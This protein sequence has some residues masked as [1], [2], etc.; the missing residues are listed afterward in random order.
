MHGPSKY[1]RGSGGGGG[2]GPG[3]SAT[4]FFSHQLNLRSFLKKTI[5]FQ[6]SREGPTFSG[7]GGGSN[8]TPG[9]G[10]SKY[11]NPNNL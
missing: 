5:V 1:R 6:D 3:P 4:S 7:G 11:K 2:W 8:F 10:G 9:G